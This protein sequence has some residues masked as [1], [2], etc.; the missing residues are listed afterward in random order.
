MHMEQLAM[1]TN[2]GQPHAL[3]SLLLLWTRGRRGNGCSNAQQHHKDTY[4]NTAQRVRA[5][6]TRSSMVNAP[7]AP[8]HCSER[9]QTR[10]QGRWIHHRHLLRHHRFHRH[11]L[12]PRAHLETCVGTGDGRRSRRSRTMHQAPVRHTR[13]PD[14]G[15]D[16]GCGTQR[17]ASACPL[18]K[19]AALH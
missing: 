15:R 18:G 17:A 10:R 11:W 3:P 6:D 2:R 8:T 5:R 12:H 16:L 19:W 9:V 14:Q 13:G 7:F 4:H 1:G